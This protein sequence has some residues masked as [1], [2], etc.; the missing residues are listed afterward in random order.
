MPTFA[1]S[2]RTRGG[3]TVNGE[4]VA[5]TADAV[6]TALKREQ[7]LVTR[8]AATKEKASAA[9]KKGKLGKKANRRTSR[10]SCGSSRS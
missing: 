8:I 3:E 1:Y 5:D 4:R 6:V 7:V 10:F 2:G 9:A